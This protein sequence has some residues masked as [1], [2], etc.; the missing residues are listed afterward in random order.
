MRRTPRH[1]PMQHQGSGNIGFQL[2]PVVLTVFDNLRRQL[3]CAINIENAFEN[4][5]TRASLLLHRV[6]QRSAV[7]NRTSQWDLI[8]TPAIIVPTTFLRK[9]K[10]KL[11]KLRRVVRLQ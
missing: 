6:A 11:N 9:K 3:P 7:S 1:T 2:D 4:R 10:G 8:I 5:L